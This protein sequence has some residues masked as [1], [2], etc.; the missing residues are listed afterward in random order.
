MFKEVSIPV[1]IF[2]EDSTFIAY[3]QPLDLMTQGKTFDEVKT[4][5]EMLVP[6]FFQELE[7]K[8][9]LL[10]VLQELGW[11]KAKMCWKPPVKVGEFLSEVKVPCPA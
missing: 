11:E 7:E 3:S 1:S 4:R 9:T 8:G 5:F 10:E 2:K 6:T